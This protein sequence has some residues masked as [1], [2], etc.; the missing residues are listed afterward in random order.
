MILLYSTNPYIKFLVQKEYAGDV[1]YVWCSEYFD[2]AKA[3][4]GTLGAHIGAT[5]DPYQI[6]LDLRTGMRSTDGHHTKI[7]QQRAG[8]VSRAR[9]WLT[10][11]KISATQHAELTGLAKKAPPDFFRPLIYVI[12]FE[13]VKA[14]VQL[15]DVKKRA[16]FGR[17]FIIP[18]LHGTEFNTIEG[19]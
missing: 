15:V 8:I 6:Y 10:D 11:G 4:P 12:P 18:D 17:E 1:H 19:L 3:P 2:G 5:S 9:K 7:K 13:P 14:R 16:S